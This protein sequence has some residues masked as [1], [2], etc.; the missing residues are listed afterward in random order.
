[1]S[2]LSQ[3]KICFGNEYEMDAQSDGDKMWEHDNA[4][5]KED[6]AKLIAKRYSKKYSLLYF[7]I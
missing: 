5:K 7:L 1:M 3:L 4:D 2:L 6:L